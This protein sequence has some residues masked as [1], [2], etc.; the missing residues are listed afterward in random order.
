MKWWRLTMVRVIVIMAMVNLLVANDKDNHLLH[1]SW[2]QNAGGGVGAVLEAVSQPTCSLIITDGTTS[3][4]TILKEESVVRGTPL[5]VAVF[6]VAVDDQDSNVTLTLLPYLLHQARQMR[7]RS[8]CKQ[9]VVV[10]HDPVFLANF[11]EW[12]LKGRLLVWATK[13]LVVTS[14]PLPQLHALLSSHWTFSMMNT[15][16]LNLED[17]PPNL[18]ASVYTYLPYSPEGNQAVKVAAWKPGSGLVLLKGRSLYSPKY[19]NFYG[20]K[21]NV[22]G[23]PFPP[24][25]DAVKGPDNTTQYSGTDYMTL[26]TVA[27]ALNFTVYIMPTTSWAEVTGLVEQRLSFMAAVHHT[28]LL[29]RMERFDYAWVHLQGRADFSMA[30]PGLKPQWQ[31]LYYPLLAVVWAAIVLTMLLAPLALLLIIRVSESRMGGEEISALVVALDLGGILLGQSLPQRLCKTNPS[32][33]MVAA[34]LVFAF[35][36]GTAYRGNLT[37]FLML[38]ELAPR[39]ETIEELVAAVDRITM[40]SYGKDFK[41]TFMQSDSPALKRMGQLMH[42]V[43]STEVGLQQAVQRKQAHVDNRRYQQLLIAKYFI[44][45]DGTHKLYIGRD[46]LFPTQSAFPIPHDAPYKPAIDRCLMAVKEA[47]LYEKWAEDLLFQTQMKA[48]KKQKQEAEKETESDNNNRSLTFTHLQGA[49][50]LLLLGLSL[51]GLTFV[52]EPLT[53]WHQQHHGGKSE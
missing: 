38:P 22:T 46:G 17:T 6:E 15:I 37:A 31:S 33:V 43:K 48:Q 51:A 2:Q 44:R 40:P 23:L 10:S 25:W 47:G 18:R 45:A 41:K 20:A 9:V 50:L 52:V 27:D 53:V 8:W 12:S 49:F 14:L 30:D 21:V 11:A 35:I 42:I 16:L 7:M 4:S 29:A 32:R 36:I 24:Y 39:P 34:W 5:G 3:T 13:L 28:V 1:Y 26:V 19:S